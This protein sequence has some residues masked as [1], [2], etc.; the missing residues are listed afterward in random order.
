MNVRLPAIGTELF[1]Q[2]C[3]KPELASNISHEVAHIIQ[4]VYQESEEVYKYIMLIVDNNHVIANTYIPVHAVNDALEKIFP[5]GLSNNRILFAVDVLNNVLPQTGYELDEDYLRIFKGI[6]TVELLFTL[7]P[8]TNKQSRLE[9]DAI[10][11]VQI[12]PITSFTMDV[13]FSGTRKCTTDAIG[14]LKEVIAPVQ[15]ELGYVVLP[16][17]SG[18]KCT[19]GVKLSIKTVED[20]TL[21]FVS[22]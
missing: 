17:S 8:S 5:G 22:V 15:Y 14:L 12:H 3:T 11:R 21:Q 10:E 4:N 20:I 16:M 7:R 18:K 9:V 2:I 6:T 19:L 1:K 13:E